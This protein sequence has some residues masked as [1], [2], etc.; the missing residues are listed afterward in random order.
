MPHP[1]VWPAY[2]ELL[3]DPVGR[4]W[5]RAYDASVAVRPA[6]WFAFDS[7]GQLLGKLVVPLATDGRRSVSIIAFAQNDVLLRT[8]DA[9]DAL[10]LQVVPLLS[11]LSAGK[12]NDE[13][14]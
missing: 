5:M 2:S 1:L 9:D 14:R 8:L 4:L 12:R 11:A 10:H 6:M 7:T 13:R 3:V